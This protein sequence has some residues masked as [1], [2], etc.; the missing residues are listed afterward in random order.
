MHLDLPLPATAVGWADIVAVFKNTRKIHRRETRASHFISIYRVLHSSTKTPHFTRLYF[1]KSASKYKC[2]GVNLGQLFS[3]QIDERSRVRQQTRSNS[4]EVTR[5]ASTEQLPSI[6]RR[7]AI[8]PRARASRTE[9]PQG[10]GGVRQQPQ[11][12]TNNNY[13][14]TR[15]LQLFLATKPHVTGPYTKQCYAIALV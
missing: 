11:P 14:S 1:T 9:A 15:G 10:G 7:E 8:A 5:E 13:V 3:K 2:F 6:E 4:H 12:P